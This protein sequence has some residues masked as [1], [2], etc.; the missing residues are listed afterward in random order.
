MSFQPFG[1]LERNRTTTFL[2]TPTTTP[3]E[4]KP[5]RKIRRKKVRLQLGAGSK[6]SINRKKINSKLNLCQSYALRNYVKSKP[7]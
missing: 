6:K 5:K 1:T 7:G 4:K 2:Q 3:S